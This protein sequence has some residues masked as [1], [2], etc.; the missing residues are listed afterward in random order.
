MN[1]RGSCLSN[2]YFVHKRE[3]KEFINIAGCDEMKFGGI[4]V[5]SR[6]DIISNTCNENTKIEARCMYNDTHAFWSGLIPDTCDVSGKGKH[7]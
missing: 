7:R 5:S 6:R 3:M 2:C 4:A 1:D